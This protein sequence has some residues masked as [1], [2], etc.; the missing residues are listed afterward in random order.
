M[1]IP[2]QVELIAAIAA[3]FGNHRCDAKF[4]NT[5]IRCA[6]E[7]IAE[8]GAARVY[9]KTGMSVQQ[10]LLSDDVGASSKYLCSVLSGDF[11]A[12]M[13]VPWDAGDF[14]RCH[15][16]LWA[17]PEL[18]NRFRLLTTCPPPWPALHDKWD[19]LTLLY[20][21]LQALT[22]CTGP[23]LKVNNDFHN[24]LDSIVRQK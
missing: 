14:G 5:I 7:I 21:S 11:H 6:N 16:L 1:S 13:N 17:I 24:A 20:T 10:W 18:K 12:E 23:W 15:R 9:S 19:E 4:M 22:F 8:A 2:S 3:P